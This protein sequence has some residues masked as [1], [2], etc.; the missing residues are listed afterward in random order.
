MAKAERMM[1]EARSKMAAAEKLTA[2]A[3]EREAM[4][5]EQMIEA[6]RFTPTRMPKRK[7]IGLRCQN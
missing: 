5:K 7:L 6:K 3:L 1:A 2:Y 4:A